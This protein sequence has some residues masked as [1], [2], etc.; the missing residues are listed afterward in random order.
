MKLIDCSEGFRC[1]D[2][3]TGQW[4]VFPKL[5]PEPG[6][7]DCRRQDDGTILVGAHEKGVMMVLDK[8]GR[9]IREIRPS[10]A[11]AQPQN[12]NRHKIDTQQDSAV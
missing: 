2:V 1:L 8:H 5:K 3:A 11:H 10:L 12:I 6:L 7:W 4:L 9:V